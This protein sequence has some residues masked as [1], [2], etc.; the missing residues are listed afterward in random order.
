MSE[1]IPVQRERVVYIL[2]AGFSAPLGLPVIRDFIPKAR[3]LYFS[4]PKA[5]KHFEA[6]LAMISE[7]AAAKHYFEADLLNVEELLSVVEMS[8]GMAG[9]AR[10]RK[11]LIRF[12]S[13]VITHYTP[14]LEVS[15]NAR[16]GSWQKCAF[17]DDPKWRQFGAFA[18]GLLGVQLRWHRD[19]GHMPRPVVERCPT[20][21]ATYGVVT[22]NYDKVLEI[23]A[24]FLS[25]H[26]DHSTEI[27]FL[28]AGSNAPD[29][30]GAGSWL[31]KLHG[32]IDEGNMVPPTW[33]KR[34]TPSIIREWKLASRLLSEAKHIRVI[35]YSLP[36]TDNY[37][38]YLL[39]TA[40]ARATN[41]QSFDVLCNDPTGEVRDRYERFVTWSELR[42]SSTLTE[43]FLRDVHDRIGVS[44]DRRGERT[45]LFNGIEP[46]H[47]GTTWDTRRSASLFEGER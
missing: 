7:F 15:P 9:R 24:A 21:Q 8:E 42:F 3:D 30:Q 38:R 33:N 45:V 4:D 1:G 14:S 26:Y 13:D 43:G 22:V 47:A 18:A 12:L 17:G 5:M 34:L 19:A 16:G 39:K 23:A 35:G 46:A 25:E 20:S 28:R 37:L 31:A 6:P 27:A 11:A 29:P 40:G 32:S 2:G 10:S 44:D 41:W 36:E